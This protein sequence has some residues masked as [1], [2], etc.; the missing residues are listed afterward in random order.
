[1]GITISSVHLDANETQFFQ[2]ELEHI[3][4][5]VFEVDYPE[6]KAKQLIPITSEAGPGAET[7]VYR[8]FDK[9]G[10]AKIIANYADDL[11]NVSATGAEF[12]RKIKSLGDAYGYSIQDIRAAMHAGRPLTS[13]LAMIAREAIEQLEN[14][15]AWFGDADHGLYGLFNHPNVPNDEVEDDGGVGVDET[16]WTSKTPAQ[17]L[18]DLNAAFQSVIDLTLGIEVPNT[19]LLPVAQHGLIAT[20]R[21]DSGTDTTILEYFRRVRP[22]ITTIE[23]VNELAG[24]GTG[25]S[26]MGVFYRRDPNRLELHIPAPF[27]QEAPQQQNLA[28]TVPCHSRIGGVT[29]YKPLSVVKFYGI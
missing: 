25:T 27:T 9:I 21:L 12:V 4:A 22:E 18:R 15:I 26:D 16:E 1:M 10:M 8:Q 28:F 29:I 6:L 24:A 11:P 13:R 5:R 23:W 19:L 7:I 14:R 20:T 3:I 2:R 17:I